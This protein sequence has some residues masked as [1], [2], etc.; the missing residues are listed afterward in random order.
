MVRSFCCVVQFAAVD[1]DGSGSISLREFMVF[2]VTRFYAKHD[3]DKNEAVIQS[4]AND[5]EKR[6]HELDRALRKRY[7]EGLMADKVPDAS[8]KGKKGK[9]S[10]DAYEPPKKYFEPF[11]SSLSI[12]AQFNF[13]IFLLYPGMCLRWVKLYNTVPMMIEGQPREFLAEDMSI[14]LVCVDW[15]QRTIQ[16]GENDEWEAY[17]VDVCNERVYY[18]SDGTPWPGVNNF[19]WMG[20]I[21]VLMPLYYIVILYYFYRQ[22]TDSNGKPYGT[23]DDPNKLKP[24]RHLGEQKT[25]LDSPAVMKMFGFFYKSFQRRYFF[26]EA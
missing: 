2:L 14:E 7:G 9:G 3:P 10:V 25:A 23:F 5:Y 6:P 20:P 4:I 19:H 26:F 16:P 24:G 11:E 18:N 15:G 13:W 21:F 17:T 12:V 8:G 1:T 22:K